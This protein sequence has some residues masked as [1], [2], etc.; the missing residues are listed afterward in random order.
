MGAVSCISRRFCMAAGDGAER[1]NGNR[2]SLYRMRGFQG[3]TS[4]SC[5]TATACTMLGGSVGGAVPSGPATGQ[6]DGMRWSLHH[7]PL[8]V[9]GG[10]DALDCWSPQACIAVG[11][12]LLILPSSAPAIAP[13]WNGRRW[14][15]KPAAT[16]V[17]DGTYLNAVSCPSRRS[18]TAVGTADR[19]TLNSTLVEHW[20][21]A[22]WSIEPSPSPPLGSVLTEGGNGASLSS[23]SCPSLRFCM[24]V[25]VNQSAT[26]TFFAE[27][28]S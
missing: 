10:A 9:D 18:C 15:Y 8:P 12:N 13:R 20:N 4:V 1:W 26:Y 19:G 28:F 23:V 17:T 24:A 22:F 6:W 25:G 11:P 16:A 2:W 21:G 27:R 14:S 3:A 7:G 5:S